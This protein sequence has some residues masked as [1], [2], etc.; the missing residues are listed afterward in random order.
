MPV[1]PPRPSSIAPAGGLACHTR[2]A[3][4]AATHDDRLSTH[5][6]E[7]ERMQRMSER[8]HHV[9]RYIDDVVDRTKADLFQP[10]GD[11]RGGRL[12]GDVADDKRGVT[13]AHL[14]RF[15]ADCWR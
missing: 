4:L 8:E 14:R 2:R 7:V 13:R 6:I 1:C 3:R 5:A 10:F 11:E 15:N 9:V 12:D